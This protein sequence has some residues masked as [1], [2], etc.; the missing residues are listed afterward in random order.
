[1]ASTSR[2]HRAVWAPSEKQVEQH[3]IIT[4]NSGLIALPLTRRDL[5]TGSLV[6]IALK[7]SAAGATIFS[8]L[9]YSCC[10]PPVFQFCGVDADAYTPGAPECLSDSDGAEQQTPRGFDLA[11]GAART[12]RLSTRGALSWGGL[13]A[14]IVSTSAWMV[15]ASRQYTVFSNGGG[16]GESSSGASS[17]AAVAAVVLCKWALAF[18]KTALFVAFHPLSEPHD[19]GTTESLAPG[20]VAEDATPPPAATSPNGSVLRWGGAGIQVGGLIGAAVF[21]SLTEAAPV[22]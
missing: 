4:L 15:V 21:F 12:V 16:G 5:F 8:A 19:P 18:T 22:L 10:P 11:R 20:E 3:G 1:M 17:V 9:A 7:L 6:S 13:S 14:I 2:W